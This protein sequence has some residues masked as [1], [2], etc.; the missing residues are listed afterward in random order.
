MSDTSTETTKK[1]DGD[2]AKKSAAMT[3]KIINTSARPIP[4]LGQGGFNLKPGVNTVNA[5]KWKELSEGEGEK[6]PHPLIVGLLADGTLSPAGEGETLEGMSD[7]DAF[8]AIQ[9]ATDA[10]QLAGWLK[11]E[12]RP[13]LREAI[14]AQIKKVNAATAKVKDA[15][16]TK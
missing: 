13:R 15:T 2:A 3:V 9:A 7:L 1:N 4:I 12:K 14:E 10:D 5:A 16:K 8:I 11:A 6:K